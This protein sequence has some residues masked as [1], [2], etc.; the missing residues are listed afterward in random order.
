MGVALENARLLEET[1]RRARESSALAEVGRDLSSSLDLATVMD[2][3]AGHA[4][5]LL[6]AGN[7]AIF[8]PDPG[9]TTYRAIVAVGDIADAIKA[10]V[11][12]RRQRASSAAS[13]R[14]ANPSSSTTQKPIRA[15]CRF[16]APRASRT[17][18]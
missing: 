12:R 18:A 13:C 10:M 7:S 3:I 11:D 8:V 6:R 16:P 1:Q 9:T 17:S 15:A 14:A 5:D 2:R 4:K